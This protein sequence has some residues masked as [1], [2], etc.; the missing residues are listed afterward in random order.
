[1][2]NH[3]KL[4]AVIS[5]IT[6]IG[7]LIAFIKHDK[8]DA[9]VRRHLNQAL[10]LNVIETVGG[11]ISRLGGIFSLIGEIIDIACLVLFIMGIVRAAKLSAEPLPLIG[12]IN[13]LG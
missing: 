5:Y 4:Y 10:V 9:L 7:W 11:F 2:N 3:S 6:W 1:M 13:W 12:E 8:D